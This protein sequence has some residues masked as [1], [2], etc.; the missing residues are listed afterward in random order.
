MDLLLVGDGRALCPSGE[1]EDD[2][3]SV[4]ETGVLCL[5]L[6]ASIRTQGG[7][8]TWPHHRCASV[9]DSHRVPSPVG[10]FNVMGGAAEVER[11]PHLRSHF[12]PRSEHF[13]ERAGAADGC[14]LGCPLT[15][16]QRIGGQG[17]PVQVRRGPA[18]VTE[19]A[20]RRR[21]ARGHWRE[22]GRRGGKARKS[23]DLPPIHP[24][25]TLVE[26]GP[27]CRSRS[28]AHSVASSFFWLCR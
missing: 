7:R 27:G 26:R 19:D 20:P 22:P 1:G 15:T 10:G 16:E 3:P 2:R 11:A 28:S 18:T 4:R 14:P 23:G 6:V 9:P 24:I 21:G 17:S 12:W 8:Q 25:R 13:R 5:R